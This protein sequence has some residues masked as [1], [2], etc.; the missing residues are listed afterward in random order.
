[1]QVNTLSELVSVHSALCELGFTK[2]YY[3]SDDHEWLRCDGVEVPLQEHHM[4]HVLTGSIDGD[5]FD[6]YLIERMKSSD[7]TKGVLIVFSAT[8]PCSL[9]TKLLAAPELLGVN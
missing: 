5:S 4:S 1:M 6:L 2:D 8:C 3:L 7:S 9:L